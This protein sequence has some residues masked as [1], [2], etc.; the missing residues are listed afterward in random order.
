MVVSE[1]AFLPQIERWTEIVVN[2]SP[3]WVKNAPASSRSSS[4]NRHA[5]VFASDVIPKVSSHEF[6]KNR[7]FFIL[8]GM[9][10]NVPYKNKNRISSV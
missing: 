3:S 4:D 9:S 6:I 5:M 2:V 10:E 7:L 1:S 8:C